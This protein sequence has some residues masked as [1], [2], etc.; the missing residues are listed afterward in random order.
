MY[1]VEKKHAEENREMSHCSSSN[2]NG[3][4]ISI[5]LIWFL[6][7]RIYWDKWEKTRRR[8]VLNYGETVSYRPRKAVFNA[9]RNMPM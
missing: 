6:R 7:E 4:S 2:W 8:F 5:F 3:T 1:T 9:A